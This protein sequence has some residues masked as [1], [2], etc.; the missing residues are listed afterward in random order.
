MRPITI[1]PDS[2]CEELIKVAVSV[3]NA[4]GGMPIAMKARDSAGVLVDEGGSF[5]AARECG[6]LDRVFF[7]EGVQ[8]IQI[9]GGRHNGATMFASAIVNG[10]GQRVAAIGVIDTL[11]VL[12]LKE[13]VANNHNIDMQLH[14][15]QPWR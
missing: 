14:G 5:V 7:G 1:A 10:H 9:Q 11:G 15:H 8:Q 13:F 3:H 6:E 4:V 2:S 12:S